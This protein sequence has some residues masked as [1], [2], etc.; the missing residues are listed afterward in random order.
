M[1][2]GRP[3]WLHW[4]R[5]NLVLTV[6]EGTVTLDTAA[7]VTNKLREEAD[8]EKARGPVGWFVELRSPTGTVT[9]IRLTVDQVE[10]G[11][12]VRATLE[13]GLLLLPHP[14]EYMPQLGPFSLDYLGIG[15]DN[16]TAY[17]RVRLP[18]VYSDDKGTTY[19]TAG[20]AVVEAVG[21][22]LSQDWAQSI[23]V[24]EGE[25]W[26][27]MRYRPELWEVAEMARLLRQEV[28]G[29]MTEYRRHKEYDAVLRPKEGTP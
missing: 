17:W 18:M 19:G 22:E 10:R 12:I 8:A 23:H 27:L 15:K 21:L 11:A 2:I 14:S 7:V 20:R 24:Q 3:K 13:D 26:L 4:P 25:L 29:V 16:Q 6:V 9:G 1:R 28:A 5:R